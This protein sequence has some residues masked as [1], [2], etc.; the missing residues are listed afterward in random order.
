MKKLIAGVL[1][2]VTVLSC[3]SCAKQDELDE[4]LENSGGVISDTKDNLTGL[5]EEAKNQLNFLGETLN[6]NGEYATTAERLSAFADDFKAQVENKLESI[7]PEYV[8]VLNEQIASIK[9]L[10][11]SLSNMNETIPLTE[12][13]A[14]K[15]MSGFNRTTYDIT[16]TVLKDNDT[17]IRNRVVKDTSSGNLN[18]YSTAFEFSLDSATKNSS[19]FEV[20]GV[21]YQ[22]CENNVWYECNQV[23][24]LKVVT[25]YSVAVSNIEALLNKFY[26]AE[27]KASASCTLVERNSAYSMTR[28]TDGTEDITY[29]CNEGQLTAILV[30][31][32]KQ[33][34]I[35]II[36][37]IKAEP[38]T[39]L[40]TSA[41][42]Y[43]ITK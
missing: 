9:T 37:E 3:A 30:S 7:N 34:Q 39:K 2:A 4:A 25:D 23:K 14:Y 35:I 43:T 15:F 5:T 32:G 24:K 26:T 31:S 13:E 1:C 19:V 18:A 10:M 8:V 16:Y 28:F 33:N 12:T 36:N 22:T 42:D 17:L 11:G 38:E 40:L 21:L 20:L 6:L 41:K 27:Y 29:V